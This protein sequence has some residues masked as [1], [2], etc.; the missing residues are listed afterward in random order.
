[1]A[2]V[3]VLEYSQGVAAAYCGKLLAEAGWDV[4]RG[5]RPLAHPL[6]LYLNAGKEVVD[7]AGA[8]SLAPLADLVVTDVPDA[9]AAV[10]GCVITVTPFGTTG[11]YATA[12]TSEMV[13]LAL[14]GLVYLVGL[15]DREPLTV[16]GPQASYFGGASAAAAALAA[17][18]G[19]RH[20]GERIDVSSM[21]TIVAILEYTLAAV[22]YQGQIR[23]RCGSQLQWSGPCTDIYE[24]Q[25]GFVSLAA[26]TIPQ[27]QS[28]A[29]MIGRPELAEDPRY[30]TFATHV[31][32]G[33]ELREIIAAYFAGKA[34]H[35]A[36]LEA[37]DWRIPV[38]PVNSIAGLLDDP[39]LEETGGWRTIVGT[40]VRV[41]APPYRVDD[42]S[43]TEIEAPHVVEAET[44]A[45]RWRRTAGPKH[46]RSTASRSGPLEGVRIVDLSAVVAGPISTQILGDLG[47]EV[48]KVEAA[49]RPDIL[50]FSTRHPQ[51]SGEPWNLGGWFHQVNRNKLGVA[52]DLREERGREILLELVRNSDVLIEN[53]SRRV[54]GNF[55]L[56]YERLA[57]VNPRLVMISMPGFGDRGPYKDYVA[58]GEIIE[59][60]GGLSS[61]TG[62][63][64]GPPMRAAIAY[65]DPISAVHA[66][67]AILSALSRREETGKG[68]Y[69]V[70]SHLVGT[71]RFLGEEIVAAQEGREPPRRG[72]RHAEFVPQGVF[73]CRGENRWIAI[74]VRT[75]AEWQAL[76]QALGDGALAADPRFATV[77][78]RRRAEDEIERR[79][80]AATRVHEAHAL[81]AA[82][83]ERG[84]AAGVVQDAAELLEDP[85]LQARGYF[86]RYRQP[87][88]GE[89]T[90]PGALWQFTH[91][92]IRVR[93][94]A[95]RLG[96]H[97][98]DVLRRLLRLSDGELAALRESGI[99]GD[100]V[101]WAGDVVD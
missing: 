80:A 23:Q 79:L 69:L 37:Q 9:F 45:A 94:P 71:A 50:R 84:V 31:Q 81:M 91:D 61:I 40:N 72:N 12:Q 36:F 30:L 93:R 68:A 59:A 90:F 51:G 70:F 66:A 5:P 73:P 77:A 53:F 87:G 17:V 18:L 25:D 63:R 56:T 58:F 22:E 99:T 78:A 8:K 10:P 57:E 47:A 39:Q 60:M 46:R 62:Y 95:P 101:P 89:V 27:W 20:R 24:T 33:A 41:P 15:P 75:D 43:P 29:A 42:E 92:R 14:A 28:L 85:Q 83:Q 82:L 65:G 49:V 86:A 48:I 21:E 67:C 4:V 52:L 100:V 98:D 38:G 6:D 34:T 16:P 88:I 54:M 19:G 32:H 55:G 74:T 26:Q 13:T 96:E 11:P 2:K 3:R 35:E 44:V 7:E 64:D 76:A 97:T 1:M